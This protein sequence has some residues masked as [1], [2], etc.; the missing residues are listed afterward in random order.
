MQTRIQVHLPR[1]VDCNVV[2]AKKN[3]KKTL[4]N[5]AIY[6]ARHTAINSLRGAGDNIPK[7]FAK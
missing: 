2:N 6:S 4:T 1:Y 3:A 5:T 7:S